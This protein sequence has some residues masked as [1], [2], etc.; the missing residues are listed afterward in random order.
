MT[1]S[2][3]SSF[4]PFDNSHRGE[5]GMK[6]LPARTMSGGAHW[7]AR[8]N[9]HANVALGESAGKKKHA[10]PSQPARE[11]L[12]LVNDLVLGDGNNMAWG[13]SYEKGRLTRMHR[14]HLYAGKGQSAG[15]GRHQKVGSSALTRHA[16]HRTASFSSGYLT[17]IHWNNNYSR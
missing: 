15:A 17:L 1:T 3:A 2:K 13:K 6:P 10:N 12:Y 8:G 9:R 5:K 7:T 14:Q 4:L 11:Y 16:H